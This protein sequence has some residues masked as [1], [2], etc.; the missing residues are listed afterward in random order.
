[1]NRDVV[2]WAVF[3][4]RG[5]QACGRACS[6]ICVGSGKD[7]ML[8]NDEDKQPSDDDDDELKAD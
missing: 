3:L 2:E 1:M 4:Q 8:R 5:L 7:W 6:G